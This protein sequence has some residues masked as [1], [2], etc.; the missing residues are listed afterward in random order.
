MDETMVRDEAVREPTR[1]AIN[2][3]MLKFASPQ[4]GPGLSVASS[5]TAS[6]QENARRHRIEYHPWM[7]AFLVEYQAPGDSPPTRGYI[8]EHR[9]SYWEPID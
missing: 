1:R 4:D 2:V 8:P 6:T 3:R 9:V 7:R 5:C